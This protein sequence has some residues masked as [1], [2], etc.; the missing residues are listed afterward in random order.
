MVMMMMVMMMTLMMS[1]KRQKCNNI[2]MLFL[3]NGI[4]WPTIV[5]TR[6][7]SVIRPKGPLKGNPIQICVCV[8]VYFPFQKNREMVRY[9]YMEMFMDR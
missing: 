9:M 1:L 4:L 8:C 3:K 5:Q 6:D 2:T 7:K